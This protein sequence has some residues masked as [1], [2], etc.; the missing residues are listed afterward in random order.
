M[1]INARLAEPFWRSVGQRDLTL[2]IDAGARVS[3]VIE[4][5]RATYPGLAKEL[6]ISP[7]LIFVEEHEASLE[8]L[9]V[10]GNRIY[11]MWPVAGG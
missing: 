3:D 1:K 11:L 5:L 10:D 6:D 8:T 2:E 4:R 9:L 7:P